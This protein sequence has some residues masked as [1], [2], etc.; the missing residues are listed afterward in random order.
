MIFFG[1]SPQGI[2]TNQ[3]RRTYSMSLDTYQSETARHINCIPVI[4]ELCRKPLPMIKLNSIKFNPDVNLF[5]PRLI[6]VF[7]RYHSHICMHRRT[8]LFHAN[9]PYYRLQITNSMFLW[10]NFQVCTCYP[11][12]YYPHQ[13]DL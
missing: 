11:F 1:T 7:P 5:V 4:L 8:P 12:Y 9:R 3:R 6:D 13:V 10:A 2:I